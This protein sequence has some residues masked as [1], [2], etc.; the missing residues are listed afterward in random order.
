[1]ILPR[2]DSLEA[3]RRI[4]SDIEVT[5][6]TFWVLLVVFEVGARIW[7]KYKKL[8]DVLALVAFALAVS[9][10]VMSHKYN[11]RRDSLYDVRE[12]Q[13]TEQANQE[14]QKTQDKAEAAKHEAASANAQLETLK[15]Q[16]KWRDLSKAQRL[17]LVSKLSQFRGTT[18]VMIYMLA[19]GEETQHYAEQ[20]AEA[21][22]DAGWVVGTNAGNHT[23]APRYDLTV[24]V[25]D[26]KHPHAATILV[27]A[28]R[29]ARIFNVEEEG[30]PALSVDAIQLIVRQKP[31]NPV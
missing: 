23:G 25:N 10:E 11:H 4:C 16:Q 5:T 14:I 8:F 30:N 29:E 31:P 15:Q 13:M 19:G 22:R 6:L 28:L 7:K 17:I 27:K 21:L 3:V 2:W 24:A 20:L 9:G 12:K 18:V 26:Q 1:M